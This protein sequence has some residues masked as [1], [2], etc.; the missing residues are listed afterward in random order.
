MTSHHRIGPRRPSRRV[1]YL[2]LLAVLVAAAAPARGRIDPLPQFDA[3]RGTADGV[4]VVDGSYVMNAGE[5]HINIT[6]WGLIGSHYSNVTTYSDA[7]SAQWPGGTGWEYLW[8]AGLW[9]GGIVL[10]DQLVSTG[11]FETEFRPLDN[12]EDTIY[13]AKNGLIL[14]PRGNESAG[15]RRLP[16]PNADDDDDGMID[17]EVLNG[18][19]DDGDGR[20]DEDFGQI[21]NQMMVTT[22]YDNTRLAQEIWP[23]HEPLNVRVVM[24]SYAWEGDDVNDFVGF[25]FDITN[26]GVIDINNMYVGFFADCDIGRRGED[27]IGEDDLAGYFEGMVRANDGSFVNVSVGF[28]ADWAEGGRAPGF[29]GVLF[30]GDV[31]SPLSRIRSFQSFTGETPFEQGGDPTND[32]E[33]YELLSSEDYDPSSQPGRENDFRFLISAGPV[34]ALEPQQTV[35]FQAAMVA[36]EGL[37]GLLANCAEAVRT[38]EGSYWDLDDNP[39]TGI[40]GRESI[41]CLEWWPIDPQTRESVLYQRVADFMDLSCVGQN[42]PLPF[43]Q[44]DDLVAYGENLHCLWVNFDNCEE[45]NR[46]APGRCER[47]NSYFEQYWDCNDLSIPCQARQGCTGICGAESA[48]HWLVGMA[49]PP[50]GMR[51]WAASNAVH[52]YWDDISEISEDVRLN[53]I[54]FESYRIWRADNWDRPFG[55]S[56]ENG[57]ASDLWR[58][59]AE[60]DLVNHYIEERVLQNGTVLRDTMPLGFNTGLE[61]IIY[62]PS[63]LDDPRVAELGEVMQ[64]IVDADVIGRYTRRPALR[65]GLGQPVPGLEDL[66][67]WEGHPA[68]L[69]TFFAAAERPGS[70][71]PLVVEKRATRFYEYIDRTVHNGFLHFYSVTATDH[72]LDFRYAEPMPSGGGLAGDPSS[73]FDHAVPGFAA[74]TAEERDRMGVNIFVY[75][76]PATVA[77]LEEF[78]QLNPNADDPT[79]IRIVFANLPRA[80]N[81]ISIFTLDGDLVAE[82]EHDGRD[83]DGQASWN[84]V[85][86]NGQQ[87]VSGIYLYAVESQDGR[88]EDYLG[89]FVIIR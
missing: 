74:Q 88:F 8:G 73:S 61:P 57:P 53:A 78:Q 5:L 37:G 40:G 58:L 71:E 82:V 80:R 55:S 24:S 66:L 35:T 48:V 59:I 81:L 39:G 27:D 36:G 87:V 19:D 7:P 4:H 2:V 20:I 14:R 72:E 52:V 15:G 79:G 77:S 29:F 26:I 34:T 6:N 70:E 44:E 38:Y 11:Q 33:R 45:C 31:G 41:T 89:K 60:Y 12:T 62:R 1:R 9:V 28:M 75:P 49:P 21:G 67:P 54:D 84:L 18:S 23:D 46:R 56:L 25:E 69:D 85:S 64:E 76:N 86:R 13:E 65:D 47:E 30:L 68:E 42:M 17:E 51:L 43:I 63:C 83:G 50:P 32:T 10:G 16:D 3:W 22:M